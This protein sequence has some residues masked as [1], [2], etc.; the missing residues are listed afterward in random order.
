MRLIYER[1][2]RGKNPGKGFVNI[3]MQDFPLHVFEFCCGRGKNIHCFVFS[4]VQLY[5]CSISVFD[6][7][8]VISPS[9]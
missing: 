9:Q 3:N 1:T 2:K 5:F 7:T 8:V 4:G 6:V